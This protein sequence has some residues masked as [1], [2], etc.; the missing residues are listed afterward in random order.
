VGNYSPLEATLFTL[1]SDIIWPD[2]TTNIPPDFTSEDHDCPFPDDEEETYDLGRIIAFS[3]SFTIGFVVCIITFII[4]KK[5]WRVPLEPM[6]G[7]HEISIYDVILMIA[8]FVDCFQFASMGP[9]FRSL[10]SFLSS[11]GDA[12]SLDLSE[13]VDLNDGVFYILL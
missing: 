6:I 2:G 7:K 13:L 3:V 8:I 1:D 10:S 9:S 4:W 11:L 12:I 5:Y